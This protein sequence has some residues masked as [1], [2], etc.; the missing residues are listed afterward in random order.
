MTI[1]TFEK[2]TFILTH[3]SK[4]IKETP[5]QYELDQC[6]QYWCFDNHYGIVTVHNT[7]HSSLYGIGKETY[8]VHLFVYEKVFT[9][10]E[11]VQKTNMS[12]E[13]TDIKEHSIKFPFPTKDIS[14]INTLL[15]WAASL[16]PVKGIKP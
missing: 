3:R 6:R 14:Y 1:P 5:W 10:A 7:N 15:S 16:P 9:R 2:P 13:I 4:D 8:E 11:D 12:R